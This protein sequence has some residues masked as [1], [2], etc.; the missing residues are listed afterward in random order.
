MF[1]N[2]TL[3]VRINNVSEPR[4]LVYKL[5]RIFTYSRSR[6]EGPAGSGLYTEIVLRDTIRF[7]ALLKNNAPSKEPLHP[8]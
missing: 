1:A 2:G 4:E 6:C 3:A 8:E 5:A 7:D